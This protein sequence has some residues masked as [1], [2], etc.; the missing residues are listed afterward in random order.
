MPSPLQEARVIDEEEDLMMALFEVP[1]A[2]AELVEA[3]SGGDDESAHERAG[4]RSV[5]I[6][7]PSGTSPTVRSLGLADGVGD[8]GSF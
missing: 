7:A 8:G 1:V 2:Q 5:S 3:S 4:A 6:S